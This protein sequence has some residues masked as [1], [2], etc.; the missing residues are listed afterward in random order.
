MSRAAIRGAINQLIQT[1]GLSGGF[2]GVHH[3]QN[4]TFAAYGITGAKRRTFYKSVRPKLAGDPAGSNPAA[5]VSRD[6]P[7]RKRGECKVTGYD[8]APHTDCEWTNKIVD[9]KCTGGYDPAND[10]QVFCELKRT[11]FYGPETALGGA[12]R[13]PAPPGK[14]PALQAGTEYSVTHG[15]SIGVEGVAKGAVGAGI[16]Y[17]CQWDQNAFIPD[18]DIRVLC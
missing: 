13:D 4:L 8:G 7:L 1:C 16:G 15:F 14:P 2:T 18:D 17:Q 11:G 10:C 5:H 12:A 9:G 6:L 3:V